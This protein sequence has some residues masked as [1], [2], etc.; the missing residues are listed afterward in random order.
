MYSTT[1]YTPYKCLDERNTSRLVQQA[2]VHACYKSRCDSVSAVT[3]NDL[4]SQHH[5]AQWSV[6]MYVYLFAVK[7]GTSMQWDQI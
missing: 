4:Q 5:M 1:V 7:T 2:T 3:D 6:Y